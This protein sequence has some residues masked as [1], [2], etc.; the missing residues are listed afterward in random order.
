MTRAKTFVKGDKVL[1][2]GRGPIFRMGRMFDTAT[3][4]EGIV[5]AVRRNGEYFYV[6]TSVVGT[7]YS[8]ANTFASSPAGATRA[9]AAYAAA[10][11]AQAEALQ[12]ALS[13]TRD[14]LDK[15]LG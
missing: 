12:D 1:V 3:L 8:S 5:E 7:E 4:E 6:R 14:T 11:K 10:L 2:V 15:V 13:Y 9:L